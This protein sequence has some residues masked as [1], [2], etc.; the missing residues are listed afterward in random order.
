METKEI[1]KFSVYKHRTSTQK[2]TTYRI[3]KKG[4]YYFIE[5]FVTSEKVKYWDLLFDQDVKYNNL[6]EIFRSKEFKQLFKK[7]KK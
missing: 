2:R 1:I 3:V 6:T 5:V 7:S 4:K